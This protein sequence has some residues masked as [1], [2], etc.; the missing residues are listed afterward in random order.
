MPTAHFESW[1]TNLCQLN[2][3]QIIPVAGDA[4]FRRYYRILHAQG[5]Y[6]GMDAS[7]EKPSCVPF[8]AIAKQLRKLGV[9]TPEIIASDLAQGFLL[10]SDFGDQ[11]YLKTLTPQNATLF[12]Q[13][14]L[15]ALLRI[16]AC[17]TVEDWTLKSFSVELMRN[18]LLACQEWFFTRYLELK[19]SSTIQQE[20]L[21]CFDFLAES[22]AAQPQVFMH[23]DYHSANLMRLPDE[24]VG[25]LDFQDAFQGPV[26]YDVVS[27]LR[28][29]YISWPTTQVHRW[30]R[31]YWELLALPQVSY[32]T[33]LRW[34]DLMGVQRHLK[35]LLTFARKFCRDKN[36]NYLQHIPRTLNYILTATEQYA[37]CQML[38]EFL[39]QE[40]LDKCVQ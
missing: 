1:L 35:C 10:L 6:I 23:R 3:Y 4:S 38:R 32:E 19:L 18:E 33:F 9:Q 28:D 17:K 22:A 5:S 21:Q 7:I 29:C 31:Y 24:T 27:L 11:L 36:A 15:A 25:V 13:D 26:T 12:Y 14:A 40:V 2:H 37:E 16:Q 8:V 34:F 39:Q 20:L 30:V